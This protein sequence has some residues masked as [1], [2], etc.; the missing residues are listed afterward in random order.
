MRDAVFLLRFTPR[1]QPGAARSSPTRSRPLRRAGAH[2]NC[3]ILCFASRTGS[4]PAGAGQLQIPKAARR[5]AGRARARLGG[6]E[7]YPGCAGHP[8]Q[9][10]AVAAGARLPV[11]PAAHGG[12]T[13]GRWRRV[14]GGHRG[15][16][17]AACTAW[18][19]SAGVAH[20]TPMHEAH[21][22]MAPIFGRELPG[23]RICMQPGALGG[24]T[25]APVLHP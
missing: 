6:V 14:T 25:R 22:G 20:A 2:V 7:A 3:R 16:R 1:S 19:S 24:E 10:P 5:R 23:C 8:H 17:S 11:G 4:V 13:V 15:T 12:G 21:T 9:R 18:R